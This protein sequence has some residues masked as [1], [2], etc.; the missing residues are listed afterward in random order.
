MLYIP[1]TPPM[2]HIHIRSVWIVR[3]LVDSLPPIQLRHLLESF[4]V[5]LLRG[6]HFYLEQINL[7]KH[8][9]LRMMV[10]ILNNIL[11]KQYISFVIMSMLA[12]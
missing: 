10:Y 2:T 11:A 3:T 1:L 5:G 6:V 4:W 7:C 8:S 9:Y 12:S